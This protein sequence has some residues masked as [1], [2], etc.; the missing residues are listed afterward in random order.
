MVLWK[1]AFEFQKQQDARRERQQL[2]AQQHLQQAHNQPLLYQHEPQQQQQEQPQQQQQHKGTAA[3][4]A[5]GALDAAAAA[6]QQLQHWQERVQLFHDLRRK[7]GVPHPA[8]LLVNGSLQVGVLHCWLGVCGGGGGGS[9]Q[10]LRGQ[11]EERGNGVPGRMGGGGTAWEGGVV[12]R[13]C[14][15]NEGVN[16]QR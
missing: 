2:E 13:Q 4:G 3:A 15:G 9:R 7:C 14:Q 6:L 10:G 12:R 16:V 1:E 8:W 11:V 5:P